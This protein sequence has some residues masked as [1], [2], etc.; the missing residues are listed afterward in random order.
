MTGR[1]VAVLGATG[2]TGRPLVRELARRGAH[3]RSLSRRPPQLG[4]FSDTVEWRLGDLRN[5]DSLASAFRGVDSI[6]YIPPSLDA[7]DP[8]YVSN[9]IVAAVRT[10][11][12]RVVYHSVLHSNT[13]E[14]PHHIRKA[15][16]ERLFR[17]SQL[18]WTI[19]QPAMYAQTVLG[20]LDTAS[21][22]LSPPYDTRQP[23]TLIDEVDLAEAAATVHIEAG[24][25]FAAYELAGAET[26]DFV[27]MAEQLSRLIQRPVSVSKVDAEA[28]VQRFAAKRGLTDGQARERW[29]MF[30]Y[31]DRHG[32]P[33]NG[34]VLRMILGRE[35]T[36]FAEAAYRSLR[37][38][39]AQQPHRGNT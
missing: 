24:H 16:C 11:V 1:T 14:M 36:T 34:N 37:V 25:A 26:L 12:P 32:L 39:A 5:V 7:H 23:F 10:G 38:E 17:H 30:D 28:Y 13:P 20:Y 27:A 2:R 6:H 9:I 31:Y 22:S 35:P 33:G 3:V 4:M 8:D 21:G 29:L 18:S 19:L 15:G